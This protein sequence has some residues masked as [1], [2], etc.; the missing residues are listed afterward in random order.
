MSGLT[1]FLL[2]GCAE[3]A[4]KP[5]QTKELMVNVAKLDLQDSYE[6]ERSFVGRVEAR[7]SSDIGFELSGKVLSVQVEEGSRIEQGSVVAILDTDIL[8]ARRKEAQAS[9]DRLLADQKLAELTLQR[10][11]K[12]HALEAVSDQQLDDAQQA[13]AGLTA[14]VVQAEASLNVIDV[15]LEKSV[16]TSPYE[17]LVSRRFIDEGRVV[18]AGTPIVTLMESGKAEAR[19]GVAGNAVDRLKVGES[20]TLEILGREVEARVKAILPTRDVR[21]RSVDVL[22]DLE[23]AME[24]VRDSDLVTLHLKR[25]VQEKGAWVSIHALAENSRGLWAVYTLNNLDGEKATLDRENVELLYYE[26]ERAFVRG[27]FSEETLYVVDGLH[28][29]VPQQLVRFR[30]VP[31]NSYDEKDSKLATHAKVEE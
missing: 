24:E 17:A 26:G 11:N 18:N 30:E 7:R 10:I 21:S 5:I 29:V 22:F 16:I 14:G 15:E 27:S 25:P 13:L 1:V 3:T 9:L 31:Q 12:A 8:D 19:I 2:T 4:S 6:V 23:L 20:H 28:K